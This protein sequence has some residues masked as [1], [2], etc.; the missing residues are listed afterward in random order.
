M[1]RTQDWGGDRDYLEANC[2]EFTT[3]AVQPGCGN[4]VRIGTPSDLTAAVWGSRAGGAV[5]QSTIA[6]RY[7]V[8]IAN[9]ISAREAAARLTT[10]PRLQV[11]VVEGRAFERGRSGGRGGHPAQIST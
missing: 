10:D 4:F 5:A 1:W 8:M 3:S 6:F 11:E 7:R 2:P 9:L